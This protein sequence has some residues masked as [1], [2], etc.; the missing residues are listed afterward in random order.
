MPPKRVTTRKRRPSESLQTQE[1]Q[2]Y[3]R[4]RGRPRS[5]T[6]GRKVDAQKVSMLNGENERRQ[7]QEMTQSTPLAATPVAED[8]AGQPL[9]ICHQSRQ[10]CQYC[11]APPHESTNSTNSTGT[12]GGSLGVLSAETITHFENN[13][14][15]EPKRPIDPSKSGAPPRSV[16]LSIPGGHKLSSVTI[17]VHYV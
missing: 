3:K 1:G 10:P 16:C 8:L 6:L 9:Q 13:T 12:D 15:D 4:G 11:R 14:T 7:R 2:P 17:T 5:R